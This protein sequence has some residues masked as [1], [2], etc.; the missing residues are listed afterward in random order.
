[1][2]EDDVGINNTEQ[3][4]ST[5]AGKTGLRET[6]DKIYYLSLCGVHCVETCLYVKTHHKKAGWDVGY[7]VGGVVL[8]SVLWYVVYWWCVVQELCLC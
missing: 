7:V 3:A 8:C 6:S 1:M 4:G 5:S 2:H